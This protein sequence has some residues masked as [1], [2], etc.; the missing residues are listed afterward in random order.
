M[1]EKYNIIFSYLRAR[2]Y[3]IFVHSVFIFI[4]FLVFYAYHLPLE[5][6]FYATIICI[7]IGII[8]VMFDFYTHYSKHSKLMDIKNNIDVTMENLPQP[9]SL[10]EEDYQALIHILYRDKINLVSKANQKH[11]DLMEYYTLWT[12]QIKTPLAAI[13]LLLQVEDEDIKSD[14][15]LQ[16][17]EV[18]K[19]VDMAL[20]YLRIDN[21][22]SDLRLEEYSIQ[23]IIKKAIKSY[24]KLFI[25]K[26]IS[27]DLNETDIRVV[28]DEKWLL[29]VVK[30]ILSN[31]LKY[32]DTGKIS[33]Y[34]EDNALSIEDTG[35][36]I[37]DE[38]IPRIFESGFT[39]YRGRINEKSTGLGLYLSKR[40]LDNL[41]HKIIVSS[42]IDMG[43]KV[44]IDLSSKKLEIE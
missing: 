1:T 17:F 20:Q 24:S 11:S 4:F 38:D 42:K 13:D 23:S 25:Y 2:R 16:I 26:D 19:Y 34:I 40:I 32:T 44:R 43:T 33:I 30:Q 18:E 37:Y 12:H 28:T 10:E 14:L 6:I 7:I 15:E 39:G 21:M 5:T 27:L 29:F 31:S 3:I 41:G 8:F 36:G 9:N 22:L 35:I